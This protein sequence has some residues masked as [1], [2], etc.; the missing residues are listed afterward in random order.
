[1]N[2]PFAKPSITDKEISAVVET[3]KSGWLTSGPKVKE[4]EQAF[5]EYVG[6]KHA[7][8]VN[9]CTSALFLSL[10][11]IPKKPEVKKRPSQRDHN[12]FRLERR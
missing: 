1:M 4:F 10:K 8:A 7:I 6:A 11:S 3:M 5:A 9:S 12:P 2:I